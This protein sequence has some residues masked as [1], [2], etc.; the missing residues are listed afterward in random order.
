MNLIS[1]TEAAK[2]LGVSKKQVQR[3][4]SGGLLKAH[5]LG[6]YT[7]FNPNDV[8]E[9]SELEN[10]GLSFTQIA[11]MAKKAH[12]SAIRSERIVDRLIALLEFDYPIISLD[13]ADVVSLHIRTEDALKQVTSYSLKEVTEWTRVFLAIGEEYFEAIAEYTKSEEPWEPYVKLAQKISLDAPREDILHD[14]EVRI[15]YG[16][17]SKARTSVR[18]TA[19]FYIQS[20]FGMSI[21]RR[22]FPESKADVHEDILSIALNMVGS[23]QDVKNGK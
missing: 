10:S 1:L 22:L 12:M 13:K 8:Y 21:A 14:R 23:N 17:L 2:I 9:L 19:F 7:L 5:Y 3:K 6:R 16:C 11:L 4:V 15:I 18:Q 20:K